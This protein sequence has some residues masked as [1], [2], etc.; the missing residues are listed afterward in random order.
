M[1]S[2]LTAAFL[3]AVAA[4]SAGA[5]NAQVLEPGATAATASG[6]ATFT[7]PSSASGGV[8][9][10]VGSNYR[11]RAGDEVT[12][13]VFGEQALSPQQPLRILPGG[14]VEIPLVGEVIIGGRTPSE[15]GRIVA[16]RFGRFVRSP[17]VTVAVFSV[18]PIETLVLG[19]VRAPGKYVLSPPAKLTDVIAAAGGLGPTDGDL[20]VARIQSPSG[21]VSSVSL[22]KLLHDGDVSLNVAVMPGDEIYVPS[23]NLFAVH[24][25]GAVDKP[26][27]VQL[28][29]GDDL[30][31]AVARAGTSASQNPDLN[32]IT[33]TR[34]GADGKTTT[35]SVNLYDVIKSGDVSRDLKLQKGD[36]VYVP[37]ARRGGSGV[38]DALLF[39]RHLVFF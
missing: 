27:D 17:R 15:A 13:S 8:I 29:E 36:L 19:N 34:A 18:A 22:Q 28:H 1:K 30:A 2:L 5:A 20:P 38:G 3:V 10:T 33:V 21:N 32:R 37:Q 24:V 9:P 11:L 14:A 12:L 6:P 7:A 26:G 39:L 4:G 16:R 25:L 31:M 35:T 23:P